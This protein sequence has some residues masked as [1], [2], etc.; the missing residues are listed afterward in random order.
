[1]KKLTLTI[2]HKLPNRIRIKTSEIIKKRERFC[3]FIKQ[4]TLGTKIKYNRLSGTIVINFDPQE[5]LLQEIIYRI[6]IAFSIENGLQSIKLIEE[7]KEKT[8][9]KLSIYSIG[10]IIL[11][12]I[13]K[14]LNKNNLTVQNTMNLFSMGLTSAAIVE[15]GFYETKRRGYFDVEILPALYLIK[16]FF[17][18]SSLS[19]VAIIWLTT[20]GRHLFYNNET[21]KN[22]KI[23]RIKDNNSNKYIYSVE[24]SEDRSINNISDLIQHTLQKK[25]RISSNLNDKYMIKSQI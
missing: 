5:I 13:H 8:L 11:S 10:S 3:N 20:F 2:L 23:F 21:A 9:E 19:V 1:M 18:T 12:G 14:G 24:L 15:H 17:N 6:S 4:G 7:K 16:S 22:I 25:G